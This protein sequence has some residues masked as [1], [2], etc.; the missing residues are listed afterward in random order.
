MIVSNI[1]KD[2]EYIGISDAGSLWHSDGA[3]LANP[4]MYSLLYGIDIPHRDGQ[5]IG[6]TAFASACRAYEALAETVKARLTDLRCINSFAFHLEKKARLGQLKR[7]PLTPEQRASMPDVDHPVV[8]RHPRTGRPY[9]FLNESH[10][11]A[12]VGMP[13]DE[14]EALLDQL[15][16]HG[17]SPQFQYRHKWRKEKW[18][19]LKPPGVQAR[20]VSL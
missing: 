3:Y 7:A 1:K 14:G 12:I 19:L 5:P 16:E 8:C 15:L 17:K 13:Q 2:G 18:H 20:D 9:L 11:S 4:D 6:D 10:T